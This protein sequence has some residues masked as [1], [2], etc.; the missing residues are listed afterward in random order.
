[1]PP[2]WLWPLWPLLALT[3]GGSPQ[4]PQ[5]RFGDPPQPHSHDSEGLFWDHAAIW[6]AQEAQ[7]QRELPP[8]ESRR[9]LG[10]LVDLMDSDSS[11]GVSGEELRAWILRRHRGS[12]EESL[13]IERSRLDLDGDGAVGWDELHRESFG[14]GEDFGG[15]HRR[16]LLRS[17]LRF[18][19]ADADGDRRLRG[20]E[21]EAFLHPEDFPHLL[22]L[23]A[24]ETI[25]ELDQN[26]DGLIQVDEYMVCSF[27]VHKRCHEFVTFECP[28][29]GKGPQTDDPRNKHKFK[30]HSYSSPTFCDHCGSLLYGLVHQ[31]MKCS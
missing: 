28:G 29:A 24:Q 25:E 4:A 11:G 21:L 17:R 26:G 22:H 13:R 20:E 7:E 18:Q 8:E 15:S 1:M 5:P 31:G 6:G 14:D 27:V 12:R 9:R 23:V 10:L 16:L 3:S 2:A 19:A 30:V